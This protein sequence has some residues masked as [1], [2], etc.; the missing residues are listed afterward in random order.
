MLVRNVGDISKRVKE[1]DVESEI[2]GVDGVVQDGIG[3]GVAD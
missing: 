2:D 1:S 3:M